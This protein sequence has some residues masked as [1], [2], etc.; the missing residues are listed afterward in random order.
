M[1]PVPNSPQPSKRTIVGFVLLFVFAASFA[2]AQTNSS[3]SSTN[4]VAQSGAIQ[5]NQNVVYA[6]QVE[7]IRLQ[8]I[9]N[10]RM[11][12]GKILKIQPDGLVVDSGYTNLERYPLNRSWLVPGT[13]VA[14]RATNVIEGIQP[15]SICIGQVFLT[16]L[17]RTTGP[18]PK[19]YDYVSLEAFPVGQYTYNSVGDLRRTVRKFSTKLPNAVEWQLQETQKQNPQAK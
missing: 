1:T 9:Q 14:A 3:G 5:I 7:K 8:C 13:V 4:S 18:K 2:G 16:D 12:C 17:P 6:Q 15:D 19:L 11:I 10:R